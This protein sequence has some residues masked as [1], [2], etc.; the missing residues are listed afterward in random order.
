MTTPLIFQP[1]LTCSTAPA[2]SAG[3][4]VGGKLTID[5]SIA[6][7]LAASRTCFL[8]AIGL[9]DQAKQ[10][11]PMHVILFRSDPTGTTFTDNAAFDVADADMSKICGYVAISSYTQ[12]NDNSYGYTT[13]LGI[14]VPFSSQLYAAFVAQGAGTYVATTDLVPSFIFFD[15]A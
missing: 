4:L 2:Y 7:G 14:P 5:N 10:N 13:A 12:F 9:V 3:D 8:Q 11:V 6:G 15:G 1:T